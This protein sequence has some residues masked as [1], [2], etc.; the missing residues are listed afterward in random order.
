MNKAIFLDRDGVINEMIF[1]KEEGIVDSPSSAKQF[2][3]IKNVP[4]SIAKLNSL[5][6]KVIIIS[7]QPGIAKGYFTKKTFEKMREKM[8]EILTKKNATL[9]DEFYCFHH[10]NA[11][12]NSYR[13]KCKCRKPGKELIQKAVSKHHIDLK[14][15]YFIGDGIVDL[16]VAKKVSCKSIFI[17][18][19]SSKLTELLKERK[20]KPDYIV[21]D[22]KEAVNYISKQK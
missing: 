6:Y 13:K 2:K 12:K 20:L 1:Q 10:P 22:L 4:E 15:S 5:N 9:D 3:I 17:G 21:H 11:K 14:K 7:N 18:N 16:E 19:V 8:H